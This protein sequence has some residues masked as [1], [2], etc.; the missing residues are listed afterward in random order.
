[1]ETGA[2][3][4]VKLVCAVDAGRVLNPVLSEG[5][6]QGGMTQGLGAG[7]SEE[8]LYTPQGQLLTTTFSDYHIYN[9]AEMPEMQTYFVQGENIA[10]GVFGAK[11]LGEVARSGVAPAL[12]N[13]VADALGFRVRQLPLTPERMLR[14]I[15]AQNTKR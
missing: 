13:A 14:A 4:V 9:A 6:V 5:Q 2:V 15:H 8:V 3:R 10:S 12:A 7:I 11:S 1:M